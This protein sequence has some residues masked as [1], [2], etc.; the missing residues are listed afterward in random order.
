MTHA[1]VFPHYCATD[2]WPIGYSG[3]EERCPLCIMSDV[4]QSYRGTYTREKERAERIGAD[5]AAARALLFKRGQ[6]TEPPCFVCGY[7]GEGYYNP[8]K[9]PCA[10]HHHALAEKAKQ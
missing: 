1:N 10:A 9:H 4:L 2:H 6:M 5:L 7:N 8:T 3:D